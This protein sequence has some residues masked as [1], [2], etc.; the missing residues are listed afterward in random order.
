MGKML[1]TASMIALL[2]AAPA[3]AADPSDNGANTN[4]PTTAGEQGTQAPAAA[5]M[6]DPKSA[7]PARQNAN[8]ALQKSVDRQG[9][10][11]IE[12]EGK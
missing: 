4:A 6:Q 7:N 12:K 9:A 5:P 3:L 1:A 11:Q 2:V 8:S 10:R